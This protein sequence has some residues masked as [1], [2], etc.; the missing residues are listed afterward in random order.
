MGHPGSRST[1]MGGK[2]SF[3]MIVNSLKAGKKVGVG[4]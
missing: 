1:Q 3:A 2:V 4:F